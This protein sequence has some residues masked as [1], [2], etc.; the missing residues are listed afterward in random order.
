[1]R[2]GGR[3]AAAID[4]LGEIEK[5]KK[6]A[7]S[8]LKDWGSAHRFAGSKDRHA[9]GSITNDA[10][11][12][13][14]SSQWRLGSETH[15]AAVFGSYMTR[16]GITPE[17]LND[18]LEGDDFAPEILSNG[19]IQSWK[20]HNLSQAPAHIQADIPEWCAPLFEAN[21]ADEW[22]EEAKA[23]THRAPLDIR[24]NTL[25]TN[26]AKLK[27]TLEA[28]SPRITEL[29]PN[30][31][32]FLP[33]A[34]DGR[35]P[36][37]SQDPNFLDGSFEVQDQGSQ[38]LAELVFPQSGEKILDYCAGAGGKALAMAA[39]MHN[40]GVIHA[41]DAD[42][43]RLK[44]IHE[45]VK[46]AGA[47]IIKPHNNLDSLAPLAG[48]MD[49][50][51]VDAPCTG[52]GTWRRRPD[53]KWSLSLAELEERL[54]QQ[55]EALASAS[56]FVRRGGFLI[57]MTCSVLPEENEDQVYRFTED[58]PEFEILS[59]GEVWQ[60][61]YGF[62]NIQ[63][64]SADLKSITLTPRATDTDGFYFCVMGRA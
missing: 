59:V 24:V 13:K 14:A 61:L 31:L 36:N 15:R 51:I 63:P 41:Y 27:E 10:L 28:S 45:R 38:I 3:L 47:S 48:T 23:F 44:P 1:M 30:A 25:K 26:R 7:A 18:S 35:L 58:N 50:V 54:Q 32:R 19:E 2:L 43:A 64:W 55:E 4:I 46:R 17:A 11:R 40:K 20:A 12:L 49:R 8:A 29:S 56:Q 37:L 52:T 5:R 53:T 21:F 22:I 34:K 33:N 42:A 9:I 57:Y 60:D 6:S 16:E 39:L 62:E